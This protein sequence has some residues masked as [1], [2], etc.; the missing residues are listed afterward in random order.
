MMYMYVLFLVIT[1]IGY[2]KGQ[3]LYKETTNDRLCDTTRDSNEDLF[4]RLL[5]LEN[6][7]NGL[8]KEVKYL[9]GWISFMD[10]DYL[11][12]RE[13]V[14]WNYAQIICMKEDAKL[15]EIESN[16]EDLFVRGLAM[17]LTK[18]VWLGGTDVGT[19][20]RWVWDSDRSPFTYSAWNRAT[21]QPNN[22]N[23]QDCLSLYRPYNLTWCDEKCETRY[24]YICEKEITQDS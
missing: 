24:Q 7:V 19:E 14:T 4:K 11:L 16:A 15:V 20:G 3:P 5:Y 13:E 18:T 6:Q 22:Y 21:G 1:M 2:S 23:N 17:K 10:S 12:G 8:K 9:K